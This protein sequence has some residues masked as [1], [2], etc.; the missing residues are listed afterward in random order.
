MSGKPTTRTTS[1][2][3][4]V[5]GMADDVSPTTSAGL[6]E[7]ARKY[8]SAEEFSLRVPR[9][10][11]KQLPDGVRSTDQVK[12][13]RNDNFKEKELVIDS[14]N[15]TGGLFVDYSPSSRAN[16]QLAENITTLDKTS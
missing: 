8:D 1:D 14:M 13:W 5:R 15:P 12:K 6:M 2:P 3:M 7:E 9:E 10:V 16:A 4:Q 11:R